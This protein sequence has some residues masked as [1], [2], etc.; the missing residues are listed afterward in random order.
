MNGR[1]ISTDR[2]LELYPS[3]TRTDGVSPIRLR[4]RK[5][6]PEPFKSFLTKIKPVRDSSTHYSK[7]KE[8]IVVTPQLWAERAN[9]AAA[10]CIA[11]ATEFWKAC[12]PSR[13]LPRYLG[14]LDEEQHRAIAAKRSEA[15]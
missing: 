7:W 6:T 4:D 12:Y 5:G 13:S 10:E 3:L 11:V 1:Y 8:P 9:K 15:D 14:C 2:K